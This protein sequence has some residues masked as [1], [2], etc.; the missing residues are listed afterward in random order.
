M[1]LSNYDSKIFQLE[2]KVADLEHQIKEL[3]GAA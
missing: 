2:A 1:K 3:K